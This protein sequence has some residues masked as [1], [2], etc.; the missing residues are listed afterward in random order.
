VVGGLFLYRFYL[1][2]VS[3]YRL[4]KLQFLHFLLYL[5]AFEIAPLLLINKLLFQFL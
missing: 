4:V 2:Y 3:V 1:S 5:A